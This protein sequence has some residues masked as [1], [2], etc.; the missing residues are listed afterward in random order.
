MI[1]SLGEYCPSFQTYVLH[2]QGL[3]VHEEELCREAGCIIQMCVVSQWGGLI[4]SRQGLDIMAGKATR[5]GKT[6]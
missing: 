1:L 2:L 3:V 5:W 4:R 6:E